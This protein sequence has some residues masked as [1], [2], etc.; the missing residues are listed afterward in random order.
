MSRVFVRPAALGLA[1]VGALLM[2]LPAHPA[3]ERAT[4]SGRLLTDFTAATPDLRW[5][6]VNDGVMGGRSRGSYKQN[7]SAIDFAGSTNTNG[8][9]FSSIRTGA[10]RLNLADF[11]GIRV[12]VR[13][14]GRR[15]TWRLTTNARWRGRTVSYWADF[16]TKPGTW[17]TSDIPWANFK[18]QWRGMKLRGLELDPANIRGM[19]AH[20][21]PGSNSF[22]PRASTPS[23]GR[24]KGPIL[25]FRS[26]T[27]PTWILSTAS[28]SAS[29]KSRSW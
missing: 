9:G 24:T 25:V 2:A 29:R 4:P 20:S 14:D 5:I 15:Y 7:G 6:V 19:E 1:L 8:G 13:G 10:L 27:E 18:P 26:H 12:R 17:T 16:D 21:S 3:E 11:D 28:M 22:S 23:G